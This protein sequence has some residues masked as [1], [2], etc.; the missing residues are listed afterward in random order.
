[1]SMDALIRECAIRAGVISLGGG[2]PA[3]ELFP[4]AR[5]TDAFAD[6]LGDPKCAALQYDWPEGQVFLRDWVARRLQHR[7]ACVD[8]SDVIITAG[9]QQGIALASHFLLPLGARVRV[10]AASYPAALE[11]FRRRE[12][13]L[14]G[15]E[16]AADCVYFMDG[17]ENPRGSVPAPAA[18]ARLVQE[19]VALIVDEAYADLNFDGFTL[20]PLMADAPDRVWHVGSLSKTLS[21][22][23]RIGWLIPPRHMVERAV[24]LKFATDLQSST[25]SQIVVERYLAAE[26]FEQRLVHIRDFYQRR[27]TV[28]STAMRRVLPDWRFEDPAGGFALF[29][30]T[31]YRADHPNDDEEWLRTGMHHGVAFDPG[32]LFT[33]RPDP[34]S[35][36][37]RLCFSATE[38]SE[39]VEAVRRLGHAW[40]AFRSKRKTAPDAVGSSL[41]T[42]LI[43]AEPATAFLV[44]PTPKQTSPPANQPAIDRGFRKEDAMSDN[45]D[46][47]LN[48]AARPAPPTFLVVINAEEQYSIW[49][50]RRAIPIGWTPTGYA[51]TESACLEHIG[52]VWTDLRPLSL[53]AK[54]L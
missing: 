20:P 30:E 43:P 6:A 10:S 51:G 36:A 31:E 50:A 38:E 9:A 24:H 28:L 47:V 54:A 2:L 46:Q 22:G 16:D 37:M 33:P 14:V 25:L 29:A 13:H 8:S 21:P 7:G 27:A 17:I 35:L 48:D 41:H 12:A 49:N 34:H 15:D 19:D 18:R 40:R 45:R 53:R 26:D 32:S 4:R 39:L 52:T 11:H 3:P 44:P 5:L 23:L 42:S 1:M